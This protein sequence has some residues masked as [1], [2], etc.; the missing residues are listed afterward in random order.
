MWCATGATS[1]RQP[2]CEEAAGLATVRPEFDA[3]CYQILC[4][5]LLEGGVLVTELTA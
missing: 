1:V 3:D 2:R 5:P 4:R